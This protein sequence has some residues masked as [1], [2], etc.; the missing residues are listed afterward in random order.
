MRRA[1]LTASILSAMAAAEPVVA[2]QASAAV[3]SYDVPACNYAPDGANHAWTWELRDAAV[4]PHYAEHVSCPDQH[5]G[6]GGSGDQEGGLSS[7][8]ALGLS[9]GAAP[10]TGAGW[11]FQASAN[12]SIAAIHYERYLGHRFD[13]FNV[14]APALR[15]DGALAPGASCEDTVENGESCF[16]GGPPGEGVEPSGLT[17]LDAQLLSFGIECR[18]PEGQQC[19]TGA[20]QHEVWAAMYGATVTI[21]DPTAPK[22]SMPTGPLWEVGHYHKGEEGLAVSPT[23]TGGGVRHVSLAVDG[24]ALDGW[25]AACDY[26]YAKPCPA[27]TGQRELGLSTTEL[28]DGVHTLTVTASDAAGNSTSLSQEITVDNGPPPPPSGLTAVAV[29]AGGS[30]FD[31]SWSD[32]EGTAAPI[33][34]ASY[35][36]CRA[37]FTNCSAPVAAPPA[38]PLLVTVPGPG[39]WTLAVWLTDAAGNTSASSAAFATLE[40]PTLAVA[41]VGGSPA[42]TITEPVATIL[43]PLGASSAHLGISASVRGRRVTIAATS[44]VSR[45]V[46]LAVVARAPKRRFARHRRVTLKAGRS[47]L[48]LTL[49]V[50]VDRAYVTVTGTGVGRIRLT[51]RPGRW[52]ASASSP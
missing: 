19:V 8:D 43:P 41:G 49:P 9:S 34:S 35:Q 3:G 4:P 45:T 37:G 39:V 25:D 24:R 51:L 12:T 26:T 46:D 11:T 16:V 18:A 20:T 2:P 15:V 22:L 48:T 52:R 1:L 44:A 21:S 31:V 40:V 6:S 7:T 38:G 23:D 36:V 29:P 47:V 17:G 42:P 14:W 13:A 28:S 50:R 33:V 10:G 30:T 32:P 27:E 5:G